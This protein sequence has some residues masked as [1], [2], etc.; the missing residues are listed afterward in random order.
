MNKLLVT[1]LAAAFAVTASADVAADA[2]KKVLPQPIGQGEAVAEVVN[3]QEEN[4][5][6]A[7]TALDSIN[8]YLSSKGLVEG[9]DSKKKRSLTVATIR[10]EVPNPKVDA[11]FVNLRRGKIGQ[12]LLNAKS[13]IIEGI[14]SEMSGSQVLDIPGNPIEG[15]IAAEKEAADKALETAKSELAKLDKDLA[16]SIDALGAAMTAEKT[17]AV[18][19]QYYAE[20]EAKNLPA[21]YKAEEKAQYAS[22]KAAFEDAKAKCAELAKKADALKGKV[23][24]SMKTSLSRISGMPI[25]GCT[26]LQQA[27]SITVENGKYIY[28]I[29]ALYCWSEEMMKAAGEILKGK[30]V[31]FTPGKKSIFEWIQAKAKNGALSQ[32][33]GPRNY[34]DNEGNMWF[35]GIAAAAKP[36]KAR[37]QNQEMQ[38]ARLMAASEV[39]FSLY[40]DAATKSTLDTVMQTTEAANGDENT[41]VYDD[42]AQ[43]QSQAFKKIQIPGLSDV[44]KGI[45][46][47]A[48]SG[49]DLQV[50]V[51]AVNSGN[52]ETLKAIN[53][54]L[55]SLGIEVNTY[56]EMERGHQ[57][58]LKSA[59]EKSKDNPAAR[60]AGAETAA[61]ELQDHAAKSSGSQAGAAAKSG[62]QFKATDG[63]TG[64][65]KGKLRTGVGMVLD[66]DE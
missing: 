39:V 66:D 18:M 34:I 41:G 32:W 26:V 5:E 28:E 29:A 63:K 64:K 7:P 46:R 44:N 55:H 47:H 23:V 56:Q 42:F 52:T 27:E 53:L 59:F 11:E 21:S 37:L 49:L 43:H 2:A 51:A 19:T 31:K 50:A 35:I 17:V 60:Q 6:P 10:F 4:V 45:R 3:A 40:A 14:M 54:G 15:Q 62:D 38:K 20:A 9:Y 8:E 13:Q 1:T 16:S 65:G 36:A 22:A 30:N 57:Q 24:E 12:L 48:P 58:M 25:Y 33:V 61:A